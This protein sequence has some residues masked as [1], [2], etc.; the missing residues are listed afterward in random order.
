MSLQ[1]DPAGST[2]TLNTL[3]KNRPLKQQAFDHRKPS[4]KALIARGFLRR[5]QIQLFISSSLF[6]FDGIYLPLTFPFPESPLVQ[7]WTVDLSLQCSRSL[8]ELSD[9]IGNWGHRRALI[10]LSRKCRG[11]I[12]ALTRENLCHDT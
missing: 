2:G 4:K 12:S 9:A 5:G 10:D 8:K 11:T 6:L 1:L 3:T 7:I